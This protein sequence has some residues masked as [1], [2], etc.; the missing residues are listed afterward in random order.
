MPITVE[1]LADENVIVAIATSPLDPV[2][3]IRRSWQD[4]ARLAQDL[5]GHVFAISDFSQVNLS[6]HELEAGLDGLNGETLPPDNSTMIFVS[7]NGLADTLTQ[8]YQDQYTG[9]RPV[10]FETIDDAL[11]YIRWQKN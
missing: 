1:R 8:A 9:R 11:A 6:Q 2:A 3:D 10:L 5:E 7:N 4:T